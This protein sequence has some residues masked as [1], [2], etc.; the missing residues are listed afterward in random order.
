M[1][2]EGD[3]P[4][5]AALV[6][7]VGASAGA[8]WGLCGAGG[9]A[10]AGLSTGARLMLFVDEYRDSN[11][12]P[13]FALSNGGRARLRQARADFIA[14]EGYT[15]VDPNNPYS[16]LAPSPI[17]EHQAGTRLLSGTVL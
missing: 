8:G 10:G 15:G 5:R 1:R 6:S 12:W 17:V 14:S 13:M 11:D 9:R 2:D 7:F 16:N 3:P 4:W